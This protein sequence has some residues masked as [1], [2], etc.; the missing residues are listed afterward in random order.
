MSDQPFDASF[1]RGAL[2]GA[3]ALIGFAI[4][5][6]GLAR[7][8]GLDATPQQWATAITSRD[9][10]FSDRPD[11]AVA[12]S[13]LA[14]DKIVQVLPAGT[15]GFVRGVLRGFARTRKLHDVGAEP[16]FRLT[17]WSDGHLTLVD[18]STGRRVD[19]GSFGPTNAAAFAQLLTGQGLP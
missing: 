18:P 3:A 10:H 8:E 11:G 12:V 5:A 2:Y 9:L 14:S 4:L 19:L 7:F 1:P 16:P 13:E 17:R 15:N 6:A